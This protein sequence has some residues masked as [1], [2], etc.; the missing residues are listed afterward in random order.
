VSDAQLVVTQNAIPIPVTDLAD[1]DIGEYDPLTRR[2]SAR[3]GNGAN[4]TSGGSV[5]VGGTVSIHF[6]VTID[7]GVT[8]NVE[9]QGTSVTPHVCIGCLE[10]SDCGENSGSVCEASTCTSGC[11]LGAA[12]PE[13]LVCTSNDA[14]VGSCVGCLTDSDCGNATSGKLCDEQ[15]CVDGCH[16]GGNGC[17]W[18]RAAVCCSSAA[19]ANG[20]CACRE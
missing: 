19:A 16:A 10:D 15:T 14:A 11:R 13:N 7:E 9:S 8:G 17:S 6:D 12:C 20:H 2:V 18:R 4:G 3:F 1:S 5:P